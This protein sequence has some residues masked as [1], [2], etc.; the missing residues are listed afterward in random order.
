MRPSRNILSL[1]KC[2]FLLLMSLY[3]GSTN[4]MMATTSPPTNPAIAPPARAALFAEKN[5]KERLPKKIP[6]KATPPRRGERIQRADMMSSVSRLILTASVIVFFPSWEAVVDV[7]CVE[8]TS[9]GDY[10]KVRRIE[11]IESNLVSPISESGT[12]ETA[13]S[14]R[15]PFTHSQ[16]H[17]CKEAKRSSRCIYAAF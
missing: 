5:P 12:F 11:L 4:R 16:P 9:L 13:C 14:F 3:Q 17:H 1:L 6:R 15:R 7:N 10:I 8:L 2:P